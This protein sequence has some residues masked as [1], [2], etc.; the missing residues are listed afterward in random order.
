[1]GGKHL[2]VSSGV[3]LVPWRPRLSYPKFKEERQGDGGGCKKGAETE[4][5]VD[6]GEERRRLGVAGEWS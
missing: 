5:M 3:L 1:M 2:Y 6:D 4:S